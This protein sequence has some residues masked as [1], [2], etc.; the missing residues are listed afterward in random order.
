ME[1]R[2]TIQSLD[3]IAESAKAKRD[4][5][6]SQMIRAGQPV[7]CLYRAWCTQEG[8]PF[9]QGVFHDG[10]PRALPYKDPVAC[11]ACG[12]VMERTRADASRDWV[13]RE[14]FEHPAEDILV[15]PECGQR[16]PSYDPVP[17]CDECD[18]YPC[19]CK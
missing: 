14:T 15:C 1:A 10:H 11:L 6:L 17:T 16:E 13:C 2:P 9:S 19:C 12:E 3:A 8:F 4:K 18:Y 5:L 7:T